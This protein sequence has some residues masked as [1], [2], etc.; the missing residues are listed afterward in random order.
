MGFSFSPFMA[1]AYP[2]YTHEISYRY[3]VNLGTCRFHGQGQ[4]CADCPSYDWGEWIVC[5]Y[6]DAENN[7]FLRDWIYLVDL[8]DYQRFW[9]QFGDVIE[10][11]CIRRMLRPIEVID[12]T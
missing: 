8:H 1:Q 6:T 4:W 3:R 5:V 10:F 2:E 7:Q 11:K 12:L 9:F